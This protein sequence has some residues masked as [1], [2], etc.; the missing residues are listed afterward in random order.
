MNTHVFETFMGLP[1]HPLVIHAAVVLIPIL[2]LVALGYA[3]VPRLRDRIG[4][5]LLEARLSAQ[6]SWAEAELAAGR[7]R[8]VLPELTDL[9]EQYPHRERFVSAIALALM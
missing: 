8:A 6:E 5:G 1:L 4:S 3:L 7:H 2:V 9:A